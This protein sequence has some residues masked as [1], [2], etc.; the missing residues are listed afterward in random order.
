MIRVMMRARLAVALCALLW[1]AGDVAAIEITMNLVQ[2]Q[3]TMMLTGG[4]AGNPLIPQDDLTYPT[5]GTTDGDP[6][7]LSNQT[8][9]QGT[10]TVDVDNVLTPTMIRI[11]S[12]NMAGDVNGSWLP[13]RQLDGGGLSSENPPDPAEPA[14][15]AVKLVFFGTDVAYG[16]VRDLV[17]NY[18]TE[19]DPE[20]D[21]TFT[22]VTEPVNAQ[23]EFSSLSQHLFY[24]SG[25]FDTWQDP[26]LDDS[27]DR[28]DLV[29]DGAP[30]QHVYNGLVDPPTLTPIPNAP[31]STYIVSG[32]VATLTIPVNIDIMDSLSQYYDGQFMAT[33]TIPAAGVAGDYNNN[34]TV[35][36]ADYVLW[37]NGGPLQNDATPGVQPGDY[38]VW[39]T[40]FGKPPA[41]GSALGASVVPEPAT[42]LLVLLGL[43]GLSMAGR[44]RHWDV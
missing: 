42:A 8:T 25:F 3:S 13:E 18:A 40:N 28:D 35:D 31:K 9:F 19:V 43:V 7:R 26:A 32:N 29:G 2:S 39:K 10:I 21:D 1:M 22:P 16:A 27:R 34:G 23:G 15:L 14:N 6:T 17:Y 20:L 5:A 11:I 24:R 38:D 44:R 33:Y 30:N 41:S 37:R 36:A 4:Y 12:A